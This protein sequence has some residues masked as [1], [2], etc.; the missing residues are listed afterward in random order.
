LYAL[1]LFRAAL[2]GEKLPDLPPK[3]NP[4]N[5]ENPAEYSGTFRGENGDLVLAADGNQLILHWGDDRIILE[6]HTKDHFY[7]DHPNLVHYFLRFGRNDNGQVVE[8]FHGPDWYVNENY[9]GGT[10]F[11]HPPE[12]DAYPGHYQSHNPWRSEFRIVLRK[13]SLGMIFYSGDDNGYESPLIPLG[14]GF[15]RVGEE[16]TS[17]ERIR[18][19]TL[20][21]GQALRARVPNYSFYR[22]TTP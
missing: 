18:F 19:D 7:I 6:E 10:K 12:W 16:E 20:V 21:H 13:G 14:E 8:V 11:Q 4:F 15:F 1:K 17:P 3:P 2:Q 22:V 9:T 5:V